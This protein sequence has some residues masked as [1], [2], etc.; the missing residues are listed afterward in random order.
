MHATIDEGPEL[1]ETRRWIWLESE[2]WTQAI[3]REDTIVS[4]FVSDPLIRVVLPAVLRSG[5]SP[6]QVTMVGM[7]ISLLTAWLFLS[8]NL[9]LGGVL[10]FLWYVVDCIDGKIARITD[11]CTQFGY[12]LDVFTDRLGTGL[13]AFGLGVRFLRAGD[14]TTGLLAFAF[15]FFWFFGVQNQFTLNKISASFRTGGALGGSGKPAT[16]PPGAAANTARISG[17]VGFLRRFRLNPWV[18][19]D[20]EWLML[21]LAIGPIAGAVTEC[22][23]LACAGMVL[24]RCVQTLGF[25]WRRRDEI[26]TV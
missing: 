14:E 6:N 10:F 5:I 23:A 1:L 13:V 18:I 21:A 3:K 15:L 4:V 8:G 20:V 22:L 9:A 16:S 11:R 19:Q 25:W 26:S 24:Q 7:G 2:I 17:Y 12:W